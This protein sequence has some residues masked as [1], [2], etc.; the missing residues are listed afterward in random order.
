MIKHG[1][2]ACSACHAD[3]SGGELLTVYGRM[4]VSELLSTR[5]HQ[6]TDAVPSGNLLWGLVSLP[7]WLLLGGAYRQGMVARL[8]DRASWR[9][10]PEQIDLFAEVDIGSLRA[11]GSLGV[12]KVPAGSPHLRAA[13][14][15]HGQDDQWNLVS[16]THWI[17]WDIGAAVLVRAGRMNLPFGV[18]TLEHTSWVR[19]TTRT[20]L[21]SD[22]QH[23]VAIAY[24]GSSVRGEFMGILGNYQVH[25]DRYRE[26]GYSFYLEELVAP[27]ASLGISSL[28]THAEA[29]LVTLNAAPIT[30]QAHGLFARVTLADPLVLLGEADLLVTSG[31]DAGHV[32]W[33]ELDL[34]P[35][36]GLHL[37]GLAEWVDQGLV[38]PATYTGARL[39]R[40]P[41]QGKGE[42]GGCLL[43]DWF[44]LP[45]FEALV[46]AGARYGEPLTVLG[47]LH[48]WL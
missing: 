42:A 16:R 13:Q 29:D 1:H 11:A 5:Y 6:D 39:R 14:V 24:S 21:E 47:Q 18:R 34:E 41:G 32:G 40:A 12:G 33:V 35:V 8:G 20:D 7:D 22:Q 10:F 15:T 9:T 44:F 46:G 38:W 37:V 3:P 36:Q 43:V 23:G 27:T 30:R 25:P 31:R 28:V 45:Q 2:A 19:A 26:R 4:Q 17:G 48:V